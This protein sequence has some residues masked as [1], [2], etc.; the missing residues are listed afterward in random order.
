VEERR[1][2]VCRRGGP[3]LV[4]LLVVA[5]APW[6]AGQSARDQI[7][8]DIDRALGQLPKGA[9]AG[10]CIVEVERDAQ[11]VAGEGGS[12]PRRTASDDAV[13]AT[14]DRARR[15]LP[16]SAVWFARDADAPMKPA[17]TM[18][19][20]VSAAAIDHLGVGFEFATRVYLVDGELWVIGGGDPGLGDERIAEK[21]G[22]TPMSVLQRW[23]D[24]LKRRGVGAIDKIVLDDSIFD[25]EWRHEDWPVDQ[26]QRWYQAPV[27]G[28]NF[29]DN[30]L[31]VAITLTDGGV[32]LTSVPPLPDAFIENHLRRGGPHRPLIDRRPDSDIFVL[33]GTAAQGGA[34]VP[35]S[36]RR[37]GT[38]FG[39][40]LMR[41][42]ADGGVAV[43]QDVVR[44]EIDPEAW[45][46]LEPLAV[47]KT[48]LAD[49]LWRSNTFSQNLF[50]ECL[51]KALAA[52]PRQA[53]S[54]PDGRG[55]DPGS[56]QHGSLPDGRG[57]DPGSRQHGSLPDGR[58]SDPGSR[59]HGSL[60]DGRGSDPG[61][62]QPGSLPDG[63]GSDTGSWPRGTQ[64]LRR[65]LESLGLDMAGAVLRDGSGLSH[66]NRVSARQMAT[67]L[68]R[69]KQHRSAALFEESLA[70]PRTDGTLRRRF[71]EPQFENRLRAKTGSIAG[72]STLA[73]YVER[74][75]GVTLAF[76]IL[77]ES[78]GGR[79]KRVEEQIVRSLLAD[80]PVAANESP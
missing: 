70:E 67:L 32:E 51:L 64:V 21:R 8:R 4:G 40:A 77:L 54:L 76:A 41:T 19:L 13:G 55:S 48:S 10:V 43:R 25:Q 62:R 12:A 75:D 69:L 20:F 79:G 7:A 68:A 6:A 18:K 47:E 2:R 16:G 42:L 60:P 65:T 73:G 22:Q 59:Q 72:V 27:G 11:R 71:R 14:V 33:S 5:G 57:S 31:D 36:A 50:A 63:R 58:G 44:R 78:H 74:P 17:S 37:P 56:R 28:I 15:P 66:E 53:G 52:Y 38:F 61:S 9:S 30:C 3:L 34:L 23:R 46:L 39:H 26:A 49:V 1:R 24:E 29:N 35:I 80:A 45:R